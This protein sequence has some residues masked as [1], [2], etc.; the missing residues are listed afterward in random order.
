MDMIEIERN[1]RE[2]DHIDY[3]AMNRHQNYK[4]YMIDPVIAGLLA[5]Q[6][7]YPMRQFQ[8]ARSISYELNRWGFR[9][10]EEQTTKRMAFGCSNTFGMEV[11]NYSTWPF[12]LNAANFGVRGA[13]PQTVSRLI[14]MWVPICKPDEIFV[15]LPE[16]GRREMYSNDHFF[17]MGNWNINKLTSLHYWR[18]IPPIVDDFENKRIEAFIEEFP[19]YNIFDNNANGGI[20]DAC[21]EEI[22]QIC[23]GHS[24]KLYLIDHLQAPKM[25]DEFRD[26]RDLVHPGQKW[27]RKLSQKFEKLSSQQD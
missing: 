11:E 18:D 2:Y 27:H 24:V 23:E 9:Q 22:T 16:G 25:T 21:V 13:S 17:H 15:L 3:Y 7:N 6:K 12:L 14:R 20:I 19:E 1:W 4:T 5:L 8:L 10:S 26:A